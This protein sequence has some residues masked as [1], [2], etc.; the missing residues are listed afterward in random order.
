MIWPAPRSTLPRAT[1]CAG[2]TS[3]FQDAIQKGDGSHA[4]EASADFPAGAHFRVFVGANSAAAAEVPHAIRSPGYSL[5]RVDL[6]GVH[7]CASQA[8]SA[9]GVA[10]LRLTLAA[11]T[12]LKIIGSAALEA[13]K[14][15]P[16]D[17][18]DS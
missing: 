16:D 4:G 2:V 7:V 10:F 14:N 18:M 15:A 1:P 6:T 17:Y 13:N 12:T 8:T 3:T 5:Y 9:S 11:P